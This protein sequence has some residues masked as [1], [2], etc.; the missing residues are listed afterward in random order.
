MSLRVLVTGA[1]GFIGQS[2]C[3]VLRAAGYDV[4]A[5]VRKPRG[6]PDEIQIG[7]IGPQTDWRAA[8]AG[9]DG[10]I[11]LAARV[12]V[13]ED[14]GAD[15]LFDRVNVEGSCNLARQAAAAGVRRF[16][17]ISSIKVNGEGDVRAYTAADVAQPADAYARSKWRAEQGLTTIARDTGMELVVLRPPLVYGPGVGANFRRMMKWIDHGVPLPLASVANRRSLLYAGNLAELIQVCM[18]HPAAAG[19][20]F[21]PSDGEDVS[22]PELLRRLAHAMGKPIRLWPLPPRLL[23]WIGGAMGE[24]AAMDRLLGSLTVDSSPLQQ[25]LGWYPPYTLDQGLVLTCSREPGHG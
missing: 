9:C 14:D 12:H 25:Q 8:L 23:Q 7:E 4:R 1:N 5:A 11:H 24:A 10:V 6:L 3:P 19:Q 18:T 15:S 17:F 20:V 21:L 22:T 16:V 13:L 2:L